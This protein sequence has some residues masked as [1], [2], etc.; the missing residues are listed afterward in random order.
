V[1]INYLVRQNG[2]TWQIADVYLDGTISELATRRSEF[3]SILRTQ[4][5]NGL[6]AMLNNKAAVLAARL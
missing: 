2:G 5:I 3:A 6:I 4:G 1:N